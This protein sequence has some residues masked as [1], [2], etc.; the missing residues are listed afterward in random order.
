M[1]TMILPAIM[2]ICGIAWFAVALLSLVRRVDKL[3][4]RLGV[5]IDDLGERCQALDDR[6]DSLLGDID[7]LEA[8]LESLRDILKEI[9]EDE[10]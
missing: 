8:G 9:E 10:E 5:E 1:L 7:D 6:M 3:E 2:S 4:D